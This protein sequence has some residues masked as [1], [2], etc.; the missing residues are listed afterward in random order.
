MSHEIRTPV[1]GLLGMA[2]LLEAEELSARQRRYLKAI[3]TSGQQLLAVINDI[4]DFSRF[5]AGK[6]QLEAADFRLADVLE[7]VASVM[8]PQA[9]ERASP[10]SSARGGG[11][12]AGA[13]GDPTRLSRCCST[14]SATRSSSPT[15]GRGH[16]LRRA[17]A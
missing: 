11:P 16:R 9:T 15:A 1:T 6:V 4:L 2:G 14:W 17:P 5:E 8:T 13:R 10:S 7:D 3:R 12:A